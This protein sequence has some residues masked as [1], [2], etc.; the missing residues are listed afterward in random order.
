ME[1]PSSRRTPGSRDPGWHPDRINPNLQ[2]YWDG[3]A[4]TASRRW[5]AGQWVDESAAP[6]AP[7]STPAGAMPG[8]QHVPA[9][10]RPY[11]STAPARP[12]ATVGIGLIGLLVSS[13]LVIFGSIT[14]WVT[15]S[16]AGQSL[17][18]S[19]TDSPVWQ[20]VTGNGWITVFCGVLLF[21]LACMVAI[22][23][24]PLFRTMALLIS[25]AAAAFAI[26]DLVRVLQSL[27][28]VNSL[29]INGASITSP[30]MPDI[31]VGWGLIVVVVGAVGAVI[32]AVS[33]TRAT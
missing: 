1:G 32:C 20:S 22:S 12:S 10:A 28:K 2:K 24:A 14:P 3:E 31:N 26:Y 27:S 11:A 13:V 8:Y 18:A 19:G 7:T 29:T 16:F 23:G 15:V 21:I 4:W 30:V 5:V 33:E 6:A 9:S 17:S 25:L